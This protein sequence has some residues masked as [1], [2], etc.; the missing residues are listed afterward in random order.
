MTTSENQ[1]FVYQPNEPVWVDMKGWLRS[2]LMYMRQFAEAWTRREIVQAPLAQL[3]W[4]HHLASL[5]DAGRL[6]FA[7]AK[8]GEE[9][10][11]GLLDSIRKATSETR[12]YG[13]GKLKSIGSKSWYS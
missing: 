11:P 5:K 10:I 9:V 7:V 4:Y 3:P 1:I 13:K 8:M 12:E 2:S 6:T